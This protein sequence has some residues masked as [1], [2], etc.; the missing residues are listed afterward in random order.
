MNEIIKSIPDKF[1]LDIHIKGN[2]KAR[3]VEIEAV[4]R[5]NQ[6]HLFANVITLR[7]LVI[8]LDHLATGVA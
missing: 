2:V 5:L 3:K 1:T 6:I 8:S 7:I 4:V